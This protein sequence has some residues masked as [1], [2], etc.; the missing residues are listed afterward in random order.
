MKLQ[1]TPTLVQLRPEVL[2]QP[3]LDCFSDS[4]S[5]FLSASLLSLEF[6]AARILTMMALS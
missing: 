3:Q 4:P 6:K 1:A 5:L 2:L